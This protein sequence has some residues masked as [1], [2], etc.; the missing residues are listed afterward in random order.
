[1]SVTG[2]FGTVETDTL[3]HFFVVFILDFKSI[4]GACDRQGDENLFSRIR[5][6][7]GILDSVVDYLDGASLIEQ[8]GGFTGID[9]DVEVFVRRFNLVD[10]RVNLRSIA[11]VGE[12]EASVQSAHACAGGGRAGNEFPA[13]NVGLRLHAILLV[14]LG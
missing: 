7:Y 5:D 1:M 8:F 3:K 4:M 2:K 13:G 9:D 12:Y 11:G 6:N 14:K 10:G